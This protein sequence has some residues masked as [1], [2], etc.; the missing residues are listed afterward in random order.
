MAQRDS[1]LLLAYIIIMVMMMM[2]IIIIIIIIIIIMPIETNKLKLEFNFFRRPFPLR[3]YFS[4]YET[5]SVRRNE[6]AYL[7]QASLEM[8]RAA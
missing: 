3:L 1:N 2:M 5:K 6:L 4:R 7:W 8:K